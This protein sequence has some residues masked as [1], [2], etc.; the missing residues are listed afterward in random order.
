MDRARECQLLALELVF[1]CTF[2][3]PWL[4]DENSCFRHLL[5]PTVLLFA[6]AQL[7]AD[8]IAHSKIHLSDTQLGPARNPEN[9]GLRAQERTAKAETLKLEGNKLFA[10]QQWEQAQVTKE[11]ALQQVD[12]S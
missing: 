5:L 6:Y 1:F 10:A 11:F 3:L 9:R 2:G 4:A 8:S 7:S 12:S